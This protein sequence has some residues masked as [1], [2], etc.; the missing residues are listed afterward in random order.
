MRTC[1]KD[2]YIMKKITILIVSALLSVF[3][4][5]ANAA[6]NGKSVVIIDYTFDTTRPELSGKVIADICFSITKIC[7]NAPTSRVYSSET[8]SHGTVMA[9]VA[10]KIDPTAKLILI[11]VGNINARTFSL[12]NITTAEFDNV[13]IP[14]FDWIAQNSSKYNIAAV[15]TSMS[16]T[17]FNKT[18]SYCPIKKSAVYQGTLQDRIVK[19]QSIG[20]ASVFSAGNTY[21]NA[22]ASYP[23]CIP[24]SIAIGATELT[25][26]SGINPVSL[27][28]AKGTD[29]DFYTLGTY[30]LGFTRMTGQTSPAAAAFASYWTK[31]YT[32]SYNDTLNVMNN[33]LSQV[34]FSLT[35]TYTNQFVNVLN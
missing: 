33:S 35:K 1:I 13:L 18:G 7:T 31:K 15:S 3:A 16:H 25:E 6:D 8:Y 17:S 32:N 26:S 34:Y 5:P 21:D 10:T 2:I 27:K 30:E 14:A 20:V 29:V 24:Q 19:L 22:R 23:A 11:R 4:L 9:T 28:S 12:S